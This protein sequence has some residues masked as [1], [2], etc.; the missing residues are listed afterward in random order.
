[1]SALK[2]G[3]KVW[4]AEAMSQVSAIDVTTA[5][6]LLEDSNV[7]FIDV[8][9]F[10]EWNNTGTIPGAVT[11]SRGMLEFVA[12]PDSPY[13]NEAFQPEIHL[14]LYC[15]RGPR[16]ALSAWRLKQMGFV[17]VSYLAGGLEAWLEAGG[18]TEPYRSVEAG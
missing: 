6:T 2:K 5:K 11:A 4:V 1:M 15:A 10:N 13:Y 8:R 12:D 14:V 18:G 3:F 9:D 16:S 7:Q 17:Q